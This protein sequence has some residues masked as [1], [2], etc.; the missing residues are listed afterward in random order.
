LHD[1]DPSLPAKNRFYE[2]TQR[3]IQPR[4]VLCNN[5]EV[6]WSAGTKLGPWLLA[7][8]LELTYT[9]WD[10]ESFAQDCGWSGPPFCWDEE[11]R[12]LL[13]AE[14]DA[15]FFHLYLPGEKNG[16]WRQA[17]GETE[18]ELAQLKRSFPTPRHA[19]TYIMNSFSIVRRRD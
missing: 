18:E 10:L 1:R 16:N 13:R 8:V 11:R 19:V 5:Y 14:V 2:S 15:A 12:F 7:R 6:P 4:R 17:D 9:A 3:L